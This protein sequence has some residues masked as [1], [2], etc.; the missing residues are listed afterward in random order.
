MP[1]PRPPMFAQGATLKE[2][3]QALVDMNLYL[4]SLLHVLENEVS[5][6]TIRELDIG[7][8]LGLPPSGA[9]SYLILPTTPGPPAIPTGFAATGFFQQIGLSWDL[10]LDP[11][12][13]GWELQRADDAGFTSNV[14][15][16]TRARALSFVDGNL[17]HSTTRYYKLRAVGK[18][19]ISGYTAVVSATTTAGTATGDDVIAAL[20][21]A[22]KQIQTSH[23]LASLITSTQ[24]AADSVTTTKIANDAVTTLKILADAI[25]TTKIADNA[26]TT[27]KLIANAVTA[28]KI[29]ALAVTTAKIDALAITAAKI[30]TAVIDSTHLRTDVAVVTVAAQI[31]NALIAT[32]H[33]ADAAITT[34]KIGDLQVVTAKMADLSV[35]TAK[36]AAA[37]ITTA[38]INDLA[39]TTAKVADANIT[40]AKIATAAITNALIANLA[41]DTANINTAAVTTA[42]I[43]DA[44][45][46]TAKIA[47]ANITTALIADANVTTAKI[48]S[49]NITT[50]LIADANV[51]TAKI[52]S[53]NITTA[54]IAD[55]NITT[56]KIAALA[57]TAAEI[58]NATITAAKIGTAAIETAKI[59]DLAVTTIKIANSNISNLASAQDTTGAAINF[60]DTAEKTLASVN[61]TNGTVASTVLVWGSVQHNTDAVSAT[62]IWELR[63]NK[64]GTPITTRVFK[65]DMAYDGGVGYLFPVAFQTGSSQIASTT[66]TWT[67]TLKITTA[68]TYSGTQHINW[69][70]ADLNVLSI[71]K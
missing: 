25:T 14:V 71:M 39:V 17:G 32:A 48:A 69:D 16:L 34:A 70:N 19:G 43:A 36:I 20:I 51:T 45:I 5:R 66:D 67:L 38:L 60:D 18:G 44:N 3:R 31:A 55:A 58:A 11:S 29:D 1:L 57:V 64:N 9:L 10:N 22:Q 46:T 4:W 47:A 27:P 28:A 6:I 26:I 63:L 50:A 8:G 68:G 12:I 7:G 59:N 13:E 56:A 24:L 21:T 40:T 54:L 35:T 15:T 65:R 37:A 49:A 61:T 52:A 53:A 30:A 2:L 62:L 41:V 23:L 42:K 33:I